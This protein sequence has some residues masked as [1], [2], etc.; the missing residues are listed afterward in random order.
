MTLSATLGDRVKTRSE[1]PLTLQQIVERVRYRR[2]GL[3]S[4]ERARAL[5]VAA[6]LTQE[7]MGTHC[8]V[9]GRAVHTW[10]RGIRRPRGPGAVRYAKALARIAKELERATVS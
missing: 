10:E 9:S 5:R 1:T 6:G 4:P 3:A 7:E 8:G 2:D